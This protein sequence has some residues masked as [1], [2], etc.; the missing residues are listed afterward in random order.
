MFNILVRGHSMQKFDLDKAMDNK[1]VSIVTS[2]DALRN[3]E[4]FIEVDD[5]KQLMQS[6]Q[7]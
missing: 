3:V 6:D 4:P 5:D 2:E 7:D 1:Q